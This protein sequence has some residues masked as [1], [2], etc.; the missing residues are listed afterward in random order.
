MTTPRAIQIDLGATPYYHCITRCVRRSFLCGE[1]YETG[2]NYNHRKHWIVSRIKYLS[3]IFP[4]KICAYAVMDNH[5]HLVLFVDIKE[6]CSITNE[7]VFKRWSKLCP[8]SASKY[9]K[10]KLYEPALNQ[11]IM[12][13]RDRLMDVSWYMKF[14][15]EHIARL[16]NKEDNCKGRFWESRFK[17]QALLDEGAILGA[18]VYVDL[19]PIR[20]G[21]AKTPESSKF[22]SIYERIKYIATQMNAQS[23]QNIPSSSNEMA[24]ICDELSQPLSLMAFANHAN[25]ETSDMP[26]INFKLSDYLQL[27]DATGRILRDDKC[28]KIPSHCL[29]IFDRLN[30]TTEGWVEMVKGLE[31]K[32]FFAVGDPELLSAFG[33]SARMSSPK[34]IT[35]AKRC[36]LSNVA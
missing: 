27:V 6:C 36:Y 11:K 14:L 30:L 22:T 29:D 24:D 1:D 25:A 34:G 31:Q 16:S 18:M 33:F 4:I 32:F 9:E 13:W 23:P 19:N 20:A 26:L 3:S 28:G 5:Y 2:K 35:V 21:T 17:S 8:N 12:Q 7:E 15:N 10:M